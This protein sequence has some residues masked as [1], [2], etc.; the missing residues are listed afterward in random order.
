MQLPVP[1]YDVHGR[2]VVIIRGGCFNPRDHRPEDLEKANFMVMECLGKQEEWVSIGGLVIVID[3]EGTT[4]AHIMHKPLPMLKKQ[5]KYIQV[6]R[7]LNL[8]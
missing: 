1:G 8:L 6:T 5:M 2:K 3:M 7:V 4:M